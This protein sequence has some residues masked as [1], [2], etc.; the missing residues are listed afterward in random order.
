MHRQR[1]IATQL[2]DLPRG[3]DEQPRL[4]RMKAISRA[5]S[6]ALIGT[7]ARPAH[8][9]PYRS[10]RYSGA[11][12]IAIATRSPG[13]SA[14]RVRSVC[15][16]DAARRASSPYVAHGVRPRWTAVFPGNARAARASQATT[17]MR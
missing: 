1:R 11:L 3:L 2:G 17:F 12:P 6:F 8:H 10:S 15:A 7:A 5:C 9:T 13:A 16:I 14:M 4:S